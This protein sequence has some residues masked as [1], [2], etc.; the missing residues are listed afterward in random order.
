MDINNELLQADDI[1]YSRKINRVELLSVSMQ[2][3]HNICI[4]ICYMLK[5]KIKDI[6]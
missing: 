5:E 1:Y 4:K 6:C 3:F 2:Q